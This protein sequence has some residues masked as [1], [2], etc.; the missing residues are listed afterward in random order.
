MAHE[1]MDNKLIM[2]ICRSLLSIPNEKIING[3]SLSQI[4]SIY[5]N[6]CTTNQ[7]QI[8]LKSP[9]LKPNQ[10]RTNQNMNLKTIF[11]KIV[12]D[13]RAVSP[14]VATL[15]LVVVAI[16]G[17]AAVGTMTG[18]FTDDVGE[19]E[20]DPATAGRSL[21]IA[22]STSVAPVAED[23]ARAFM[24]ANPGIRVTVQAG[25]SG[26][27]RAA[28][29]QGLVDIGMSSS[30]IPL[31]EAKTLDI[32]KIGESEVVV[33]ANINDAHRPVFANLTISDLRDLYVNGSISTN[34]SA[35]GITTIDNAF[36]RAD[37][38]G[39][40]EAF[41]EALTDG[42]VEDANT[43][44]AGKEGNAGV[45]AAVRDTSNSIGFVD[46][47][48]SDEIDDAEVLT[49]EE[50]GL[51]VKAFDRPFIMIT[52]GDPGNLES[53]FLDFARQ[54]GQRGIFENLGLRE[55]T[56]DDNVFGVERTGL[57]G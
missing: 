15:V 34:M 37:E 19:E 41:M 32:F 11:S 26:A 10:N 42:D 23:L 56:D 14:V 49:D 16:V 3:F 40:E 5:V 13:S 6:G 48:F 50:I 53:A 46:V 39:T 18:Q 4:A 45:L 20:V 2:G 1:Q 33:I 29:V 8:G 30:K 36:H 54:P 12:E 9:N 57:I 44:L 47:G 28:A 31:D 22:G 51:T 38:S 52:H 43:T 35:I 27:G 7:N 17:A 21:I 25:G 24:E 55:V